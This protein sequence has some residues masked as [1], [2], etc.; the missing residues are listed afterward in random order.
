M[1]CT[2]SVAAL[3]TLAA[4]PALAVPAVVAD[5]VPTGALVQDVMGDLGEVRV[6][7][8]RGASAHH[9]Q[10]RPSDAQALQAA[11][12]VVWVGPELT[13][14]LDR[15]AGNLGEAAQLRLLQAEGTHLRG[16]GTGEAGHDDHHGHEDHHDHGHAGDH[17]H[18]HAASHDHDH[19]HDHEGHDHAE[20]GHTHSGT[21]PHAWLDPDNA[22]LWLDAIAAALSEQ[23]PDNAETYRTNAA[24]TAERI[25]ALDETL[26]QRLAPHADQRFAVFHD[27]YGY[28]TEHFG[29]QPA[30]PVAIG[31][32]S[33][34][35]AA[36]IE[37]VRR[38]ITASGALC[39]FPEVAHDPA[40]LD[41]V[42]EG[43][44]LRFGASLSPEGGEIEAGA[45]QYDTVLTSMADALIGC[46]EK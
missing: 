7:L 20:E 3:L 8:P 10:M 34:P 39:A 13:P 33:T 4:A 21:D 27:A 26:T 31:D 5:L 16:Y 25:A 35:S 12:L 11:D 43:S 41:T 23:D 46:F 40:L 45:G 44:S 2:A 14:W 36:R 1:R 38:D 32:A 6:L 42:A 18:D 37:A 17:A 30:V 22:I 9:Y 28:F 15:A 29:L 24:A 19:D